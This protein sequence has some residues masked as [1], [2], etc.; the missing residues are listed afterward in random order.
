MGQTRLY[1]PQKNSDLALGTKC[2][3]LEYC[4]SVPQK[5]QK[6]QVKDDKQD[7]RQ[8]DSTAII[9]PDFAFYEPFC[10][11]N[12]VDPQLKKNTQALNLL[13]RTR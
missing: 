11:A 5:A 9:A 8:A 2:L 1:V 6:M 7:T 10:L 12:S 4:S 13:Q 3:L